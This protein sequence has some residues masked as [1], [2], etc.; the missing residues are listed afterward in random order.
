MTK[1]DYER[2]MALPAWLRKELTY[3]AFM[4]NS[5]QNPTFHHNI[6]VSG[7]R[8]LKRLKNE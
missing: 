6:A 4:D 5:K 1:S 8:I 2:V 7:E 3:L